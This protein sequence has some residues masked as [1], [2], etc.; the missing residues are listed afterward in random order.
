MSLQRVA[1][2]Y[3]DKVRP[4]T[5]GFYCRRAL[6]GLVEVEHFL[7]A[8]LARIP[9][10][11][12]DLYLNIDDGLEY[13]LPDDLRPC[14]WW[15]IDTHLNY[16][17]CLERARDFD[18]VFAAQR[19]GAEQFRQDGIN[20]ATWLPLACDPEFHCKH[21]VTKEYD[22]CF[23]GNLFL[24]ARSDLVEVIQ[25]RFL[26]VFVGRKFFEEMAKIYSAS[27]IVF[28]RSIR[29]D[30]NMRVFEALACGSLLMTN[31]LADNGQGEFFQDGVHLATY[32]DPE[33]LLDKIQYYLV[34]E[35]VRERIAAT[36]RQEAVTKHTYRQRMATL[37]E[38]VEKR[39]SQ[40]G[41]P[42]L[43][44]RI[45]RPH[46][47]SS[48][49][50]AVPNLADFIPP[51]A[52][53]ILEI[54]S[55]EYTPEPL[56]KDFLSEVLQA[57]GRRLEKLTISEL[58]KDDPGLTPGTFD[59]I[60]CGVLDRFREPATFLRR[61]HSRL[62]PGGCVLAAIPNL[63]HYR[64][65][66]TLME[67]NWPY[68]SRGIGNGEPRHFF[69]RRE[70]EKLFFRTGFSIE[71]LQTIPGL[72]DERD[73]IQVGRVKVGG[74][75]ISGLPPKDAEE[76][77]VSHYLVK[78]VPT[79]I[80]SWELTSIII[81]THN[82]L[83]YTRK[84]MKSILQFTDEPY[85]LII[86]DNAST[87]GT[88][89]FL[90]TIANV[91]LIHN[92]ENVGFPKAAN[93][94]IQAA[95]GRQILL[96]NN[97]CVVTTGWLRRLLQA[98]N[99][100]PKIGL[101]GP[102]SNF[103]S[104]EQQLEV[105]YEDLMGLD[106]FA[107]N[108]GQT[109]NR[110]LEDTDRLVGFCFLIRRELVDTI[111]LLDERFG[112]GC[113]EDDDYCRRALAAGYRAVIARDAYVHHFGGRTFVG[114]GVDFGTLSRTN[115][116][117]L[118]EKWE[119][120]D[121]PAAEAITTAQSN[122]KKNIGYSLRA[123]PD[124]GLLLSRKEIE[125]SLCMIVRDNA[126]TIEAALESIKPWVD[127]IIVVDT[128]S[129]DDTP[130]IAK[131]L[132]ARVFHFPWCDD[133]SAARNESLRHARGQ[134]IFWMDSDDTIDDINGRK[135]RELIRQADPSMMGFVAQVHCPGAG[136]DG[137][138]DIT[139]VD[140]VKL[141]RNFPHLR[142]DGRIHE[143]IIPALRRA[144]GDIAWTDL[145]V[146]HS[147]YDHTPEG[148]EKKKQRDLRI[149]HLE[150]KERPEHPFTL[151]NLGMTYADIDQYAEAVDFLNRSIKH[152][153]KTESHLRKAFAILV[154]SYS[155]LGQD[156]DAWEACRKGLDLFPK[157][158]EL[159]F[160]K[161][162][163]LH[164]A[165]R[166]QEAVETYQNVLEEPDERHF[167]SVIEGIRGFKTW[168]NLA[169]VY[170]DLG[171]FTRAE[172]QWRRVVEEVPRYRLGWRGLGEILVLQGKEEE[173]RGLADQLLANPRLRVEG[174]M[175]KSQLAARAGD[176]RNAREELEQ[177]VKEYPDD[178]HPLQAICR[179]LFE[180]G[181]PA[182][183]EKSLQEL[184]R[185]D[186]KDAAAHH[187]LGMVYVRQGR[188]K[189]AMEAFR[190][191]LRFRPHSPHT[192]LQLANTLKET[193]Q[194]DQAVKAWNETL[195][196]CPGQP[197]A[198]EALRRAQGFTPEPSKIAQAQ[199]T[200]DVYKLQIRG[201]TVEVPFASR[202]AVDRA[203]FRDVCERDVYGVRQITDP[204]TTV[205][206]IGAHIGAFC[207]LAAEAWPNARIIACEP[208]PDNVALLRQNVSGRPNIE[209]VP[210]AILGEERAQAEFR[211]VPDKANSNSGGG[212]CARSEPDSI[213]TI[214]PA[215][216]AVQLWKSKEIAACDFLKLDCEGSELLVL[217]ALDEAGL[218][219]RVNFIAGEWHALADG[220]EAIDRA[221]GELKA[222]LEKTHSI[223]FLPN[224]GGKEGHFYGQR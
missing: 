115:E 110:Q 181:E 138:T 150:L 68:G 75:H 134:W 89:E 9:R 10:R 178:L 37:L 54:G 157:D 69:T 44:R 219:R 199:R 177:A 40:T 164:G 72:A 94:G 1:I 209:V 117:L 147:G 42:G 194:M 172:E 84:C 143:Q 171:D 145:F 18:A 127:E 6:G 47:L 16:S 109:H 36:G 118:T 148:Q 56:A 124:G 218:L 166:F 141:F 116:K 197:E 193:G 169:A 132:G 187:N 120:R 23:V 133:F 130:G 152:S 176:F 79:P 101:V 93:Q 22:V 106:G 213:K 207:L 26:K 223:T 14:A 202:G 3:D 135:L 102:C 87:D 76:F 19:D 8:E 43:R 81:L 121:K 66:R 30:V 175:V 149:L 144:G 167:T 92:T 96:L 151:F 33:E 27:R 165:G 212:S 190:Q 49:D 122:G 221:K 99:G 82:E 170:M 41:A 137:D 53:R 74:L 34:H 71:E 62:Q 185:H 95:T 32:K 220:Q 46:D 86:V 111:G 119:Q 103:V 146:V 155:Q 59:A 100:D 108:W 63:R 61:V 57:G 198:T 224:R 104:G 201:R 123:A 173:A 196:Q 11:E 186:P 125:L 153:E 13:R 60:V 64:M 161:A 128:G 73:Q 210:A 24:G 5:T 52:E 98:L 160:R 15:A 83:A 182:Q 180:H 20:T 126:R 17:W 21:D 140:H 200:W 139:V 78:A 97:D 162:I 203:I 189:E 35:E 25:R 88:V 55:G 12:F 131:R 4:D 85:E 58:E 67:G 136:D 51:G 31:D 77:Y 142:F 90:E 211:M 159:R 205:L 107:W 91:K 80:P 105:P 28:N 183:A 154:Y 45:M 206:D 129:K 208:D 156:Q 191:S 65:V 163:L 204:P 7:P 168:H 217:R 214:V 39:L 29:N 2:I 158:L 216:S 112:I 184:V 215:L 179:L 114:M 48:V 192:R 222:T 188:L 70:M 38:E 113:F 195:L 174:M 50:F